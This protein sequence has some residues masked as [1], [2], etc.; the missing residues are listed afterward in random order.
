MDAEGDNKVS[1]IFDVACTED[2]MRRAS[3]AYM[4]ALIG[5]GISE[6]SI[7]SLHAYCGSVIVIATLDSIDARNRV[8]ASVGSGAISINIAGQ[9]YYAELVT[10][11]DAPSAAPTRSISS[12]GQGSSESSSA[13]NSTGLIIGVVAAILFCIVFVYILYTRRG[14]GEPEHIRTTREKHAVANPVYGSTKFQNRSQHTI[15]NMPSRAVEE[16]IAKETPDIGGTISTAQYDI[17]RAAQP[18]QY[19]T[20]RQTSVASEYCEPDPVDSRTAQAPLYATATDYSEPATITTMSQLEAQDNV[21]DIAPES[22]K[23]ATLETSFSSP[24]R[25]PSVR[26]GEKELAHDTLV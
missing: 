5:S 14:K 6:R 9:V 25:T 21:G 12:A 17:A 19:D 8:A 15:I 18:A 26:L 10:V 22:Q 13:G 4:S 11:T 16:V 23:R 3:S 1:V 20:A 2:N 7:I 24:R